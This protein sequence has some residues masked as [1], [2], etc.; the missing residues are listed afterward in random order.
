MPSWK[1]LFARSFDPAAV[2]HEPSQKPLIVSLKVLLSPEASSSR[3]RT[4]CHWNAHAGCSQLEPRHPP[5]PLR[6][7]GTYPSWCLTMIFKI[8]YRFRVYA[9]PTD[10][11]KE[12]IFFQEGRNTIHRLAFHHS[13]YSM[14]PFW[15]KPRVS[16]T[17]NEQQ[18]LATR[19]RP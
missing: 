10:S 8:C 16:P 2:P 7:G 19:Q 14:H 15:P 6:A 4:K 18:I 5:H 3:T 17:L 11:R 9:A 12:S 13:Q 1:K